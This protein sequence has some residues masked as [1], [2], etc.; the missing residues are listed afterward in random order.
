MATITAKGMTDAGE[1]DVVITGDKTVDSVESSDRGFATYCK[2]EIHLASG[3]LANGFYPE[4][5]TMLQAYAFCRE[6]FS[7]EQITVDGDIGEMECE[8]DVIY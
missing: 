2:Q 3:S 4:A 8:K 1:L 6:W 5:D 7:P